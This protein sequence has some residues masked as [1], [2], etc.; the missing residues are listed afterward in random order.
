MFALYTSKGPEVYG[1]EVKDHVVIGPMVTS[2]HPQSFHPTIHPLIHPSIHPPTHPPTQSS[3][4]PFTHPSTQHPPIDK[5]IH[6]YGVQ[7][8]LP[9][10]SDTGQTIVARR[11]FDD[12]VDASAVA[13]V[14]VLA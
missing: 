7:L 12:V 13:S 8:D 14:L 5:S 2:N 11:G 9:Q 1:P 6:P 3:I 10:S 4:H